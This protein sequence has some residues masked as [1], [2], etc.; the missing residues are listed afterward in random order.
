[1]SNFKKSLYIDN[2]NLVINMKIRGWVINFI[3]LCLII[4]VSGIV[5]TNFNGKI[6]NIQYTL[7]DNSKNLNVSITKL[8]NNQGF[9]EEATK[10]RNSTVLIRIRTDKIPIGGVETGSIW[11]DSNNI[12]YRI[13]TG[14][15][16]KNGFIMTANHVIQDAKP[17]D[18]IIIWNNK[19]Y[20][21]SINNYRT[22]LGLDLNILEINIPIPSVEL[23]EDSN[24]INLGSKIGFIGF[25]LGNPTPI[26]ND[27]I[28]SSI[29][30]FQGF[31][32]YT[33]NSFV[34]K[35]NSGGAVFLADS[36]K[37]IGIINSR[38]VENVPTP[39]PNID[40]SKFSESEKILLQIQIIMYNQL[41]ANSQV[42]IG[43]SMSISKKSLEPVIKI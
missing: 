27:G 31:K 34:N 29:N 2:E 19:E 14:F 7:N 18:I 16:I 41:V 15:S 25:P 40:E 1:M 12:P 9:S 37:V 10:I 28:I 4:I 32:W 24:N 30:D 13:G 42:G 21:N 3:L 11:I 6:N 22:N 17:K 20:I 33:I 38:V 23:L 36:G 39:I 43:Q 8:V 26:L 35:G 5:F